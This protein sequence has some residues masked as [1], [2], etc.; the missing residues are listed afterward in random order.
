MRLK[1][2]QGTIVGDGVGP[3]LDVVRRDAGEELEEH[4]RA[5]EGEVYSRHCYFIHQS[6]SHKE[7]KRYL[8]LHQNALNLLTF[9]FSRNETILRS[10]VLACCRIIEY[11]G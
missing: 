7:I 2:E 1:T 3:E 9:N 5:G 10:V 6:N 11:P 4:E 8:R